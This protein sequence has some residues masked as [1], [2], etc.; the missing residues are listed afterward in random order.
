M[1]QIGRYID[2]DRSGYI[3]LRPEEDEDMWHLYN[4]IQEGDEVRA[5]AIRRVQTETATGSTSSHRVKTTLTLS[6][7]K[8]H[9]S[10]AVSSSTNNASGG[11]E[12]ASPSQGAS[13]SITGQV[14]QENPFVKMGAYHTLDLEVNR[15]VRIVKTEWDSVALSR[16]AEACDEGKGAEV[17]A[18]VCG[19]GTAAVCLLSEH[20]TVIRQRVEVP[21]P[22]K[23][24]GSTTLHD[25]GLTRFYETLYQSFLRHI[26]YSSLR[27]V[28]IASPGFVK[29]AV[30][31]YIFAEAIKANNKALLQSKNKF[32]RVHVSSPHVHSL[33]EVMKSPE[34]ISQLKE[35]KFAREGIMLD[36]FHKML[37]SDEMRA[38]YG[39]DHVA[40]A[41]DRGAIGTLLISDE[42]F[43]ASDPVLRKKYV[44]LV[45]NVRQKGAEVLIFS[46]MH[47]SG[48]QLNQLTGIAAILTFPLDVEIVEA[49]E[50][51]EKEEAEGQTTEQREEG[52]TQ[53]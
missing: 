23:R 17:G 7:Q 20:M 10:A 46:S 42:L 33:M 26:P 36:K 2:K 3:T 49:E 13:L 21:V 29:D 18:I 48:Q 5:P 47:E 53:S 9:F 1:K 12:T 6:V 25:K 11:S 34:V 50:R 41:A 40:L 19:E 32:L 16:A 31:D 44:E 24:T 38:W 28:V 43:R 27:A 35:T 37:G 4:L 51:A 15:D 14:T 30:Y 52:E 45:E 39:P 22:R 8:M